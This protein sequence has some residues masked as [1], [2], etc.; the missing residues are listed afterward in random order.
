MATT[1]SSGLEV[2]RLPELLVLIK[3]TA[4][5]ARN[6]RVLNPREAMVADEVKEAKVLYARARAPGEKFDCT[7]I[8]QCHE[9]L[10]SELEPNRKNQIL[11]ANETFRKAPI[12]VRK[13]GE[14]QILL[15]G[16][17]INRE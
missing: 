13:L 3:R 2:L 6:R 11:N 1:S 4:E 14:C 7:K 10:K 5:W 17:L 16:F 12:A 15:S 9:R 8:V